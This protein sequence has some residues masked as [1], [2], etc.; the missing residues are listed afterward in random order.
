MYSLIDCKIFC[1]KFMLILF[2]FLNLSHFS[3]SSDI[4]ESESNPDTERRYSIE[5]YLN[6]PESPKRETIL[7]IE[8]EEKNFSNQPD[9]EEDKFS[10]QNTKTKKKYPPSIFHNLPKNSFLRFSK[11]IRIHFLNKDVAKRYKKSKILDLKKPMATKIEFNKFLR[12]LNKDDYGEFSK[13][14]KSYSD[15]LSNEENWNLVTTKYPVSNKELFF[16]D[17]F[18]KSF[19]ANFLKNQD[20]EYKKLEK[21]IRRMRNNAEISKQTSE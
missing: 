3:Y 8:D 17:V 19:G 4:Y 2:L 21:G 14:V 13:I 9:F 16:L 12:K 20:E 1:N 11:Y 7:N 5:K 10:T 15:F 18:F 6:L